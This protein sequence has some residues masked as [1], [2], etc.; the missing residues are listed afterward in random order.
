MPVSLARTRKKMRA[1]FKGVRRTRMK[2]V[3]QTG[4]VLRKPDINNFL[5]MIPESW[6]RNVYSI[7]VCATQEAS[8]YIN[9]FHGANQFVVYVSQQNEPLQ[10]NLIE[11]IAISLQVIAKQ[12]YLPKKIKKSMTTEYVAI[13]NDIKNAKVA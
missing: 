2:I 4:M 10:E 13:W 5:E 12:G 8:S 9:Y 11:Q 3:I 6:I 1:R 7:L